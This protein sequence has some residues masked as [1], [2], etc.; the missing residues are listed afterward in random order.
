M[1][2]YLASVITKR[3][4]CESLSIGG[5]FK[6]VDYNGGGMNIYLA[7]GIS[8]N[9]SSLWKTSIGGGGR[10]KIYLAG[11]HPVKNG[12]YAIG[13][14][15]LYLNPITMQEITNGLKPCFRIWLDLSLIAA[16]LL[17]CRVATPAR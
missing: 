14:G 1:K 6:A 8:G 16:R 9:L 7:G 11:E 4:I 2:V 3:K 15:I 17:L 13:G 10:M 5:L 12:R